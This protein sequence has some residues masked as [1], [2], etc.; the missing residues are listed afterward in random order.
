MIK[1]ISYKTTLAVRGGVEV[2]DVVADGFVGVIRAGSTGAKALERDS[3]IEKQSIEI[4][5]GR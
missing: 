2:A 5:D 1:D 3:L 4:F